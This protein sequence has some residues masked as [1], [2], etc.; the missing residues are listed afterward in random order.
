[1]FSANTSTGD[2]TVN[3]ADSGLTPKLVILWGTTETAAGVT[4]ADGIFTFGVGTR[5]GGS[6][7]QV[8][9]ASF[10]DNGAGTSATVHALDNDNVYEIITAD[11]IE[12]TA[13]DGKATL[14]SFSAGN[15]VINWSNAPTA[16]AKIN[17]QVW[18]G[19]DVTAARVTKPVTSTAVG[20][21]DI[22]VAASWGQPD[23]IIHATHSFTSTFGQ[24]DSRISLGFASKAGEQ[25][26]MLHD[27]E[28][29]GTTMTLATWYRA[30]RCL[31]FLGSGVTADAEAS[32]SASGSWPTDGYQITYNDQASLGFHFMSLAIK[33]SFVSKIGANEMLTAGSTQDLS[34]A[35]GTPKGLLLMANCAALTAG[36]ILTT[37]TDLGGFY[38]GGA[39][40]THEGGA[41]TCDLDGNTASQAS[42]YQSDTKAIQR[43]VPTAGSAAVLN[44]EADASVV[45]SAMQLNYNDLSSIAADF[46]WLVV[47]EAAAATGSLIWQ[48]AT[49]PHT[50]IYSP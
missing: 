24:N 34:L 35:S 44:A 11:A 1:M 41:G 13:V 49:T 48:P 2:Q 18:G 23:L 8:S 7:Q 19:S 25:A 20:T 42:R 38:I 46:I 15:F 39:D 4:F 5:D 17:Y 36:S 40:G 3:L 21:Q 50:T 32:I 12:G 14:V 6:T 45:G 10:N 9:M 26:V 28:D 29:A 22:T 31:L 33:G 43:Y 27:Y 47:G 37:G 30:D 16:A